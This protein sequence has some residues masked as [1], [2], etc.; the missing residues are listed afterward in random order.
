VLLEVAYGDHQVTN[1][2]AE[3]EARTI[4]AG[5]Y[6]PALNAGRHWDVDP[7][8]GM[9]QISS[10]PHQGSMLVYYDSGPVSFTGNRGQGIGKPPLE[11]MPPR[12]EWGYG[13]DPHEDPRRSPDGIDQA[14]TFLQNGTIA[15]CE[16]ITPLPSG[17]AH[18]YANG[19]TGPTP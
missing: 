18:C 19:Y 1:Y 7:F 8:L 13:R 17:D 6:S 16:V 2:S 3:V 4:G 14:T 5:I 12:S 9:D 10:F 11:E 15:S